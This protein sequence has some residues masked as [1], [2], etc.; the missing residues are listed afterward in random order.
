MG[1]GEEEGE[2][3]RGREGRER[4]GEREKRGERGEE[5]RE[6]AFER[7]GSRS[8]MMMGMWCGGSRGRT[9]TR[10]RQ[11]SH[12]RSHDGDGGVGFD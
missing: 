9:K 3:R 5:E 1:A 7:R 12:L 6:D 8:R 11:I 10:V 2:K 4:K